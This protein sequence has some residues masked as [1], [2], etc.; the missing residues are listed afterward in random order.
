MKANGFNNGLLEDNSAGMITMVTPDSIQNMQNMQPKT[1][2]PQIK[3]ETVPVEQSLLSVNTLTMPDQ[4]NFHTTLNLD[5]YMDD[6]SGLSSDPML[7]SQPVS[8]N[9]E[10][11]AMD[12][13]L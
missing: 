8:P 13:V 9:M 7:S 5:D 6:T 11:D 4:P 12:Y 2:S 10:D 1:A 3:Q